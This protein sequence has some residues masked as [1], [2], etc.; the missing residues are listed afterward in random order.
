VP[1]AVIILMTAG[2]YVTGILGL[3][4][5]GATVGSFVNLTEVPFSVIVAWLIV[6]ELPTTIQMY[7]GIGIVAGVV[8]IKWGE[9]RQEKRIQR[10][11]VLL[12]DPATGPLTIVETDEWSETAG[13]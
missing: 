5:V 9:V 13:G 11:A 3:R 2:A 6:A 4:M 12:S 7:G 8:F 10:Q 1:I